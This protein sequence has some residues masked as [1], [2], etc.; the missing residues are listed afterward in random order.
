MPP[1]GTWRAA[2]SLAVDDFDAD[3][4]RTWV[5]AA[6]TGD[7]EAAGLGA[8]TGAPEPGK[9]ADF[10]AWNLVRY[11]DRTTIRAACVDGNSVLD[12]Q[13][14]VLFDGEQFFAEAATCSRTSVAAAPVHKVHTHLEHGRDAPPLW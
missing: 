14:P 5:H 7:A 8:V 9:A 10:V 2:G 11:H 12:R 3:A 1:A 6:T 4:G 13:D